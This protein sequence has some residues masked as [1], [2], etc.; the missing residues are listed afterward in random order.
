VNAQ[1]IKP[2]HNTMD[3]GSSDF[4]KLKICGI[5]TLED[6]RYASGALADFIGFIFYEE[7]PR[8]ITPRDAA[9]IIR[10]IEGPGKIGV[11]VNHPAKRINQIVDQTGIDMVQL[12]GYESPHDAAKIEV[13]VVK[14]FRIRAQSDIPAIRKEMKN[15]NDIAAYYLFDTKM[16][17]LHGGTGRPWDWN[18][19]NHLLPEKPFFLAGGIDADNVA[20]AV[21]TGPPYGVD[22]SSS[23]EAAPGVKDFDKMQLFFDRWN[24]LRDSFGK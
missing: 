1:N 20:E 16:E 9:E 7:S 10:W 24:E 3:S 12:H 17:Q 2:M 8:Y 22:L 11:F 19:I 4:P 18:L 23:I 13:P 21:F 15:W 6:A 14:V 5:T